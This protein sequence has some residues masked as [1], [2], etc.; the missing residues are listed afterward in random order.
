MGIFSKTPFEKKINEF[1][2][3]FVWKGYYKELLKANGLYKSFWKSQY[4]PWK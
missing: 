3:G 1:I 4:V 2:G